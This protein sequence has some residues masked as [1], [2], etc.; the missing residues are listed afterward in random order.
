MHSFFVLRVCVAAKSSMIQTAKPGC[1]VALGGY[2][3]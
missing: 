1:I 2:P 3:D